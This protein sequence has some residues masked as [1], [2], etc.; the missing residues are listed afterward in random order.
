MLCVGFIFIG[1]SYN[2]LLEEY[3]ISGV[4]FLLS[5]TLYFIVQVYIL[6]KRDEAQEIDETYLIIDNL[7]K[8]ISELEEKRKELKSDVIKDNISSDMKEYRKGEMN[9]V[10]ITLFHLKALRGIIERLRK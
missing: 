7:N 1:D 8:L 5:T 2:I 9:T 4:T 3:F 6:N 10:V